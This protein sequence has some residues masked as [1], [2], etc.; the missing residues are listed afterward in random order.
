M[1]AA[2][3]VCRF[4]PSPTGRL[5][6]GNARM[7]LVNDLLA[8]AHG[9]SM[10]L[11]LDDTDSER[12]TEAF[13]Q[14]IRDDLAWLGL[15]WARE[16]K[17]S[18]RLARYDAAAAALRA[19][20]RLYAC[21]ETADEL[22][23]MRQ[24][25]RR[26]GKPP[27]YDR[28]ALDLTDEQKAAYE[29][30]GRRP[31]WRFKLDPGPIAWDDLVRGPQR[32]EGAKL[33]DPVLI[34]ED[35]TYLYMLPSAVDDA[36]MGVTHVVRGEDH[37]TNTAVQIQLFE[38]LGA[39]PP[40][41]AH[42]ALLVGADGEALSKRLGS[43][44]VADFRD[45]GVEPMA[46]N[47]LLARLGT[48]D[49]VEP[50]AS[51][52]DLAA[53][54]DL[55]RFGRAQARFDAA[56]L[57]RLNSRILHAMDFDA[58]APRLAERGIA[59]VDAALWRAVRANLE[60][61]DDAADWVDVAYGTIA[62]IRDDADNLARAAQRLPD[63]PFDETTWK[64]WTDAVKAETGAKG[65]ALFLPLRRALTG[66][67]HGPDMGALLPLIGRDRALARLCG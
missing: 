28:A 4:A 41:F 8:R 18:E 57:M 32:F 58:A 54:F 21:Y 9:G 37:V 38:A 44:A 48:S 22:D 19:V 51:L 7:A 60:R 20:G 66:R 62:P 16:E 46:L 24:R 64:T 56:E 27:I 43:L 14:G 59:G 45:R 53:D 67:D 10:I 39:P 34:R 65:K 30:E 2:A 13:A 17:Q 29:A 47:A 15:T 12:S 42:M 33:S 6:V 36:D 5:H 23:A 63:G 35:G 31:H 55:S 52:D 1:T 50:A 40:A 49:A 61:L 26:R 11:R 3:V 25:L